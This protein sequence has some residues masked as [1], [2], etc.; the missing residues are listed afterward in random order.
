MK[1]TR[2]FFSL[3]AVVL[4]LLA[5]C[6][7]A[8]TP[9]AT[10]A[11]VTTAPPAAPGTLP[12][13]EPAAEPELD[14]AGPDVGSTMVWIDG[15]LLVFVP[16]GEF[17]MGAGGQDNPAH[18]VGLS[19]FWVYRT[20]VTN[21]MY[22]LCVAAGRCSPPQAEKAAK[23]FAKPSQRDQ[24]VAGVDW[25]QADTYCKWVN[26]GLPTEAQWE[27][28]ARGPQSN[29][30]PWGASK[31]ACDLLNFNNCLG[32]ISKVYD[33]PTGKS[34][35][36]ALD[37]AG[38]AY[39]WTGDWYGA[40]YYLTSPAGDPPG[41]DSGKYRVVRGSSFENDA[42]YVPSARRFYYDP[43]RFRED[44]GFR[45]VVAHPTQYAPFCQAV[46]VPGAPGQYPNGASEPGQGYCPPLSAS[47]SGEGCESGIGFG[48]LNVSG[49]TLSSASGSAGLSCSLIDGNTGVYCIGAQGSSGTVEACASGHSC[50]QPPAPTP[51]CPPG[52]YYDQT[53]K[54]CV[55][56]GAPGV[57]PPGY[58]YNATKQCCAAGQGMPYPGCAPDEY[59]DPNLGCVS[60]P[61]PK[62][63]CGNFSINL[64][65]CAPPP[66]TGCDPNTDP[67]KCQGGGSQGGDRN[68]C[69]PGFKQYCRE[70]QCY[71][72]QG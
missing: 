12:P 26:G 5:A 29:L 2:L 17:Q 52:T 1:P 6:A 62:P 47:Q 53:A 66:S 24:P 20:K 72:V 31:P 23:S 61:V 33:F 57:C 45:C 10:Q 9:A 35:F 46:F 56:E 7:P 40:D 54:Q 50:Q 15:S 64:G 58:A 37:M 21:R 32:G 30:Y 28:V 27:L 39:E 55:G 13:P 63:G 68:P 71:C 38:N 59:Y 14:L 16:H 11:P 69:P 25:S 22:A 19:D 34:Y 48:S 4:V 44:L 43:N 18:T 70:D 49:D 60:G 65:T 36:D 51:G 42:T 8:S 41:P 67:N 3:N